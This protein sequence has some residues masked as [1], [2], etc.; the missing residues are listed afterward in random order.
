MP[1]QLLCSYIAVIRYFNIDPL[2]SQAMSVT[3]ELFE[4]RVTN[5]KVHSL[6]LAGLCSSFELSNSHFR[7]YF[8]IRNSYFSNLKELIERFHTSNDKD[9]FPCKRTPGLMKDE[10]ITQ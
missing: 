2:R 5:D 3:M 8:V 10:A 1:L 6:G 9:N 4:V 7:L